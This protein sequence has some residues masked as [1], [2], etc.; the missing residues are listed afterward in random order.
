VAKNAVNL[1][2]V[3]EF[4]EKYKIGFGGNYL[5]RRYA[6]FGEQASIPAY[7]VFNAMV[8]YKMNDAITLQVNGTNLGNKVFYDAAYY[9]SVGENHVIPGPGRTFTLTTGIKF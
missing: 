4:G 6:D 9:T 3:Y 2:T 8:A 1:W 7:V 5:G